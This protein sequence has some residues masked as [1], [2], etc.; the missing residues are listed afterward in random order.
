M[1]S[2]L[3]SEGRFLYDSKR[4]N[5]FYMLDG[6]AHAAVTDSKNDTYVVKLGLEDAQE[7]HC[8]CAQW[9]KSGYCAHIA[10]VV[11]QVK[12]TPAGQGVTSGN[13]FLRNLNLSPKNYFEVPEKEEVGEPL[14][15]EATLFVG[16]L[17]DSRII[18][19]EQRLFVSLKVANSSNG[20]FYQVPDLMDFLYCYQKGI[21]FHGNGKGYFLLKPE[22][23]SKQNQAL[24][25]LFQ[26]I[27]DR[28][29]EDH[30]DYQGMERNCLIPKELTAEMFACLNSLEEFTFQELWEN[31]DNAQR[32]I[33]GPVQ[34]LPF[35]PEVGLVTAKVSSVGKG[36]RLTL[37]KN[38]DVALTDCELL[39]KGT[40][41]Y[42]TKERL[43]L[44]LTNLFDAY[45]Q[46]SENDPYSYLKG[47][48]V[49]RRRTNEN[50]QQE[51]VFST[52]EVA[53]LKSFILYFK[54]LGTISYPQELNEKVYAPHFVVTKEGNQL[55]IAVNFQDENQEFKQLTAMESPQMAEITAY[56]KELGFLSLRNVF[57]KPF[58]QGEELYTL[59]YEDIPVLKHNGTVE[60]APEVSAAVQEIASLTPQVKVSALDGF[61][62]VDFSLEGIAED[63]VDEILNQLDENLSYVVRRDGSIL[64]LDDSFRRLASSLQELRQRGKMVN[65]SLRLPSSQAL[66]VEHELGQQ[67]NFATTLQEMTQHLSRPDTFEVTQ[68]P[69]V[70]AALRPYQ[71]EGYQWLEMLNHYHF[72]GILADEMGLGKTL[73][74]ITFLANHVTNKASLAV[75]P[76]SLIFNWQQECQK[77]APQLKV[78]VVQGTKGQRQKQI[79]ESDAHLLITSYASFRSD[80]PEY[81]KRT[82]EYL[83][84][85]EAQAIK[86]P[87]SKTNQALRKLA[88]SSVFALSGTPVEN[89]LEELWAIF[90]VVLPGLL[91]SKKEFNQLTPQEV[92][93]RVKPFILRREKVAVLKDLPEMSETNV[94][95]ELTSDQKKVYLAQLKQMQVKVKGMAPNTFVQNKIEI[96]AGLTRLRQICDTPKL[97]LE[98]YQGD[99]GK[100]ALLQE[101]L[102]QAMANGR[103]ILIFSQFTKMLAE[104]EKLL[105]HMEINHFLLQGDTP[106]K[107]RLKMV[108]SFNQGKKN[109]FLISLKAGGTG[110][111][112]TGADTVILLDLWW[113]PA[114]EEQAVA[115]AHRI[116]QKKNIEVYRLLTKGTIEEKILALQEGKRHLASQIF[117]ETI[118]KNTLTQE[119]IQFILGIDG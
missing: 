39:I 62:A 17:Q 64:T 44:Q 23:F 101:I 22:Y 36:Y 3:W 11:Y 116:G 112:L 26:K 4:I 33:K 114:V 46:I 119:D 102:Q 80:C 94:T 51:I 81:Q 34:L 10:A 91:P 1:P 8:T 85:D 113:N 66:L 54:K 5:N 15:L 50:P 58:P 75:A 110:L 111:N 65:G 107:E 55:V 2:S 9:E 21:G 71:E 31:R 61:L 82:I 29:E 87:T 25:Q 12:A 79:T 106:V 67:G 68:K 118:E 48:Y 99:S 105:D 72:G 86:N 40:D 78:V 104:V 97:F 32:N 59:L 7:D 49:W 19:N 47:R 53:Q 27:F 98:D 41:F 88:V 77:F 84:L 28:Y 35:A 89:R 109:V 6:I 95:T 63:E 90:E 18:E 92:A 76:A 69:Q 115:R 60:I 93:L 52:E 96:L 20:K 37:A 73:Q 108:E 43:L 70:E 45:Q 100:L 56:F 30:L 38:F 117:A 13:K 14:L 16:S 103:H 24:I 42:Q 57:M 83:I 74:M